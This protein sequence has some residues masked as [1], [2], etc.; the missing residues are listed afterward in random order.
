[1]LELAFKRKNRDAAPNIIT[2]NTVM[3]AWAKSEHAL[4]G[5]KAFALMKKLDDL[6]DMGLLEDVV[7][8]RVTYNTLMNAYTKS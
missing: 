8:D 5:E 7:A 4:A 3:A 2:F 1:M 6:H